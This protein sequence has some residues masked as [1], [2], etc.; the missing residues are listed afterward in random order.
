MIY[1][2]NITVISWF[3]VFITMFW[4]VNIILAQFRI[5]FIKMVYVITCNLETELP[6][7][8]CIIFSFDLHVL[9]KNDFN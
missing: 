5:W 7:V 6:S 4:K 1:D 8:I 3:E 9:G 2:N